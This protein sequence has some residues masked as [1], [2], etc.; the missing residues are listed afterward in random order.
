[1]KY[2]VSFTCENFNMAIFRDGRDAFYLNENVE[3]VH[4]KPK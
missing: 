2:H 1:M 4:R 3:G